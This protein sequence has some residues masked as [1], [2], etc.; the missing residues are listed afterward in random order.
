MEE[1]C[2]RRGRQRV[3]RGRG[4]GPGGMGPQYVPIAMG[5]AVAQPLSKG[6]WLG[7]NP[8][9]PGSANRG[10]ICRRGKSVS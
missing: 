3:L 7:H 9:A 1:G 6:G 2:W 10:C 5:T 8:E 4:A